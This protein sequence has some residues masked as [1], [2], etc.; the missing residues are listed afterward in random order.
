MEMFVDV[1]ELLLREECVCLVEWY[2]F[3]D[4][5][6]VEA[7]VVVI[8]GVVVIGGVIVC[9][10]ECEDEDVVCGMMEEELVDLR[11]FGLSER[12]RGDA[13]G[14][15]ALVDKWCEIFGED[16]LENNG[17]GVDDILGVDDGVFGGGVLEEVW[18]VV[19]RRAYAAERG[20][21]K[22]VNKF[23]R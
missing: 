13:F 12:A 17:G 23:G 14:E 4:A 2:V 6:D 22:L 20:W 10:V 7:L 3:G 8:D 21:K 1:F 15:D 5:D 19:M 16:L 18:N 11:D 9:D